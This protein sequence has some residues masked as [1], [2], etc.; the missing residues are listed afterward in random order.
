MKT[1]LT[2]IITTFC[3]TL[4]NAQLVFSDVSTTVGILP[5]APAE[6]IA[7]GD[8]NN[9]GYDDFYVC[10]FLGK[11]HLYQN[12]G[13]S[14]VAEQI[15]FTEVGEALG[16]A[17]SENS[18]TQAAVWGDINNDGWL[19]LYVANK[20]IPD[21]LFLN[22]GFTNNSEQV[23]FEE[24]SFEV[25]IYHQGFPKSVNMADVN[26]DGFLDIYLSNFN[27]QNVLYLSSG[28]TSNL[29]FT[30][31][32]YVSGALDEGQAMGTI[33]FDYDKD[34]DVDL[35]LVHDWFEPNFLY[36]NDE[37][38]VFTEVG[39]LTGTNTRSLGMGVDVGDINHD[40][41][42]DIYITNLYE[43][44]LLLNNGDGTF[45]DISDSSNTEDRGM[46]WGSLFLD[47]N[48]D[49]WE[50]IYAANDYVYSPFKNVLYRNLGNL[51]F[52]KVAENEVVCNE[53]GTYGAATFDYNSDGQ[54][55]ILVAN[56][57]QSEQ[58]QLFENA[59]QNDNHWLSLKLIG[60]TSNF[61]AIGTRVRLVDNLGTLHY[62]ELSAGQ[63]WASQNSSLLHFGL[64]NATEIVEATIFWTSGNTENVDIASTNKVY[65]I[66][67]N[68]A[69]EEG[70]V[71]PNQRNENP[72]TV[73]GF[74]IAP[75]PNDGNFNIQFQTENA[76]PTTIEI[77]NSRGQLLYSEIINDVNI[78]NNLV[79]INLNISNQMVVIR[80]S[81]DNY[82]KTARCLVN[83]K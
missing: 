81:N 32:I 33:F 28:D 5:N 20:S 45:T 44:I 72:I 12:N 43:N 79:P 62:Q 57:Y 70:I 52:E 25:G 24:I 58:V 60:T 38:G 9:D 31:Y 49:S 68:E 36:Q 76:E 11:N 3:F 66:T 29:T 16:V 26:N 35:Y 10:S 55:D 75:N 69:I 78:G 63:S 51:T 13:K 83:L 41:W 61:S 37:T 82:T 34:G 54:I 14:G 2:I 21:Q 67:E 19:D 27:S 65:T 77:Y 56:R 22:K 47:Y 46:G 8:F 73:E 4:G 30:N 18:N 6:G 23:T 15:K 39:E 17:L 48:N 42:L 50:D 74:S 40:G 53:Y 80:V 71:Y 64:G 59:T 7:V 1:A